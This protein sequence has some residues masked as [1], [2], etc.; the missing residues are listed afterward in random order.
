MAIL[1]WVG[2]LSGAQTINDA[3]KGLAEALVPAVADGCWV[4][5]EEPDGETR[6]LFE[7][8]VDAPGAPLSG[9]K[10]LLDGNRRALLPL[11]EMA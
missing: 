11:T 3:I 5:L 10:R 1:A 6:R 8:G 4:D 7:H 9:P 2:R